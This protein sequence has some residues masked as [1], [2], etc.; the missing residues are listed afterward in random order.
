[1]NWRLKRY[2][3]MLRTF[4]IRNGYRRASFL[5]RKRVFKA[6]GNGCYFQIWNFGT[7]P[8]M[9]S[10][11][12]NVYITSGVRFVTHDIT[13]MMFQYMDQNPAYQNRRG[14]LTIG[15]N[16]FV[17]A[18]TTLLYDVTIGDNVIIGAG[19]VVNHDIPSGSVAAGVPCRVIGSFWDYKERITGNR[20]GEADPLPEAAARNR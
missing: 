11:G 18:N 9:I 6:Q 17:G 15:N 5:R 14:P 3:L 1:M 4:L 10:F 20:K 12:E 7:E 13:A 16:V 19:S 2:W 8:H